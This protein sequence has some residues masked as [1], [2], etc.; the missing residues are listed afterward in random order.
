MKLGLLEKGA[1]LLNVDLARFVLVNDA[2]PGGYTIAVL[3]RIY[4]DLLIDFIQKTE[5]NNE[6]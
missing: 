5:N 3:V 1:L 4:N 2:L 6:E